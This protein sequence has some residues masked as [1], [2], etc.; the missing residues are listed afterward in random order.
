[1]TP[2]IVLG[3]PIVDTAVAI[4]RRTLSGKKFYEADNMHLHHRL[5]AMGFTH[6]GAVLV[7]YGIAMFF[8]FVSLLLN[9]SS[10]LGGS[11]SCWESALLLEVFIEGLEIWGPKR[12]PLFKLLAFIGNS[13]YCQA[14]VA[15]HRQK[16][17]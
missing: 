5:L 9:I 6:R 16:E 13:D 2:I 14:V 12:T 17:K 10:R 8:S 11:C 4:I 1:M 3:V 7:V 15:K